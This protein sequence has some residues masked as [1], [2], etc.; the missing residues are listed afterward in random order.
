M[1]SVVVI[2]VALVVAIML[3]VGALA[4]RWLG[5]R[6]T[7]SALEDDATFA[8]LRTADMASPHLAAGLTEE[9]AQRAIGHLRALLDVDALAITDQERVLAWDGEGEGHA[10]RA[11]DDAR[12]VLETGRPRV[13][14]RHE[15]HGV[16]RVA[17]VAPLIVGGQV[18]GA[19]N[20]YD[21]QPSAGLVRA[22]HDLA[23][24]VSGQLALSELDTSRARL[25]E[26]EMRALRAQI[27]PHF[28]YNCLTTIAS[29]VRTDPERARELLVDFADFARY[30]FRHPRQFTTLA[31]ELRSID[32]YLGLE[33]ARFG[34]RLRCSVRVAPEVLSVPVPFLALQ[35]LVENAV[36]HGIG[37]NSATGSVTIVARE[38]GAEA[39]VSVEDDGVGMEPDK[40]RALLAGAAGPVSGIGLANV[41]ERMRQVY[42]DEYG[43][44]IET[45]PGA[46][47]KVSLRIPKSRPGVLPG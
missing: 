3:T 37:G 33:Q 22:T 34:D 5:S 30:S 20:A 9:N 26:A 42:G 17:V 12:P 29:F 38:V 8:A 6:R 35:P 4:R 14:R 21:T 41:D 39:H 1:T 2:H 43:L 32:R 40:L 16:G 28:I 25:V 23:R 27:S 24:W 31:D 10:D 44:V 19:L 45:A 11:L 18:A 36:Q 47:T 15:L 13:L 46:G 7:R